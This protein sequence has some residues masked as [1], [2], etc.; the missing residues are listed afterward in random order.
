MTDG[1]L[2]PVMPSPPELPL[3]GVAGEIAEV[4]GRQQAC[5]LIV[6]MRGSTG[7][8]WRVCIY[9]PKRLHMDHDLVRILGW[10]D[11]RRL[12]YAFGGEI[13]QTSNLRYLERS[14]RAWSIHQLARVSG[15]SPADISD[16]IG[17]SVSRVREILRGNPPEGMPGAARQNGS[18]EAA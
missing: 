15:L 14:W 11:A 6:A 16:Q 13:L 18:G 8:S 7:R 5:R 10:R 2:V 12:C 4:I 17:L 1:A 9:V 3:V